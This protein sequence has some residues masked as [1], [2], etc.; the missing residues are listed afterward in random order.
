MVG[1]RLPAAALE[2]HPELPTLYCAD[3]LAAVL[4]ASRAVR[5]ER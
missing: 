4:K 5:A 1:C 2:G 3:H